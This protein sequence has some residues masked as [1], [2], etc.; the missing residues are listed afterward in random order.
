M[1]DGEMKK[2]V[3]DRIRCT[4]MKWRGALGILFDC[5][6]PIKLKKFFSKTIIRPICFMVLH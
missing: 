2:N 4:K 5:I 3:N 1:K 6:I